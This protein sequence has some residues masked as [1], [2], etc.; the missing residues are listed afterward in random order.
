MRGRSK[1]NPLFS[2]GSHSPGSHG[3]MEAHA[4]SK[5]FGGRIGPWYG[6]T[7]PHGANQSAGR[8]SELF[9]NRKSNTGG[10]ISLPTGNDRKY[11]YPNI[12]KYPGD[13]KGL[14]SKLAQSQTGRLGVGL[15]HFTADEYTNIAFNLFVG[16]DYDALSESDHMRERELVAIAPDLFDIMYYSIEPNFHENYLE[17]KLDQWL[18]SKE[19]L[20]VIIPKVSSMS[21]G[22]KI[23]RDIGYDK[24]RY[25]NFKVR[26]QLNERNFKE[27]KRVGGGDPPLKEIFYFLEPG[28]SGRKHILT[29]WVGGKRVGD[30]RAV[31]SSSGSANGSA[32]SRFGECGRFSAGGASE[33]HVPSECID[34]GGRTGYSVK[35]VSRHYL[36][37][38][39]H[40]VGR[41][42]GSI[43]NPP[44]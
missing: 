42:S 17:G 19:Y 25:K 9:P 32:K 24:F 10:A 11:L 23:W 12:P 6:K 8:L 29:S 27:V 33:P 35:M 16:G 28:D 13:K 40:K 39:K 14:Q 18:Q 26:D 1:S 5:P 36:K 41:S 37:S 30:Y 31:S 44:P 3:I 22:P 7:W 21:Y 38:R 2:P 34:E 20:R 43:L 4:Y 15:N